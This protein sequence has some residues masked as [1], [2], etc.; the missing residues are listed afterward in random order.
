MHD[1]QTTAPIEHR[2]H[3]N[4][5][6]LHA[7]GALLDYAFRGRGDHR[8]AQFAKPLQIAL[9]ARAPARLCVSKRGARLLTCNNNYFVPFFLGM[10]ADEEEG[11]V[12]GI[13]ER[14]FWESDEVTVLWV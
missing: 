13:G 2:G 1:T 5:R 10:H 11:I 8:L 14:G 7:G 4:P 9:R 12:E 6:C 3:T